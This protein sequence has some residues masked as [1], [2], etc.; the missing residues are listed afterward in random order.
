MGK[1]YPT[2]M[3]KFYPMNMGIPYPIILSW[4]IALYLVQLAL[5]VVGC[6]FSPIDRWSR[7]Y[8]MVVSIRSIK[9]D[10]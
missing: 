5:K 9:D 6:H 8:H 4:T 7:D 10:F 2:N 3:G 1:F